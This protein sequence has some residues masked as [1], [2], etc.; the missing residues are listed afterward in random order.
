[1]C[2]LLGGLFSASFI[3]GD[4]YEGVRCPPGWSAEGIFGSARRG[5]VARLANALSW[6]DVD[7]MAGWVVPWFALPTDLMTSSAVQWIPHNVI[8][9]HRISRLLSY[10][11]RFQSHFPINFIHFTPPYVIHIPLIV[12][13][14]LPVL[15]SCPPYIIL[16]MCTLYINVAVFEKW[17]RVPLPR[18]LAALLLSESK[19]ISPSD[20]KSRSFS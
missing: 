16:P 18:A 19:W 15:V 9:L 7:A 10:A 14:N 5:H 20:Q 12:I 3:S 4:S 11:P 2:L 13:I 8:P 17:L 1:M 6:F